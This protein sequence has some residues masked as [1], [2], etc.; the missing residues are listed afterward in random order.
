M[1]YPIHTGILERK[2]IMYRK[3]FKWYN[4]LNTYS[5][6][7]TYKQTIKCDVFMDNTRQNKCKV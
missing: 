1:P 2:V 3:N 5:K 7:Y 4:I 6:Q